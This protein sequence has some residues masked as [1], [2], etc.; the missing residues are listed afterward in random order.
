[1]LDF[2]VIQKVTRRMEFMATVLEAAQVDYMSIMETGLVAIFM[3]EVM[4]QMDLCTSNGMGLLTMISDQQRAE[5][6][7]KNF[8]TIVVIKLK[9][10]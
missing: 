3:A 1:M 10:L 9:V 6:Q 8:V 7:L 2:Q 4:A 5:K